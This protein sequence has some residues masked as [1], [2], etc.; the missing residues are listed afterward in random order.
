M[1]IE[2][3]IWVIGLHGSKLTNRLEGAIQSRSNGEPK[4]TYSQARN[5]FKK[6]AE[7]KLLDAELLLKNG[8]ASNAYYLAGYAVEI[9]FKACIARQMVAETIPDKKLIIDT[10]SHEFN[11]LVGVAGLRSELKLQQDADHLFHANWGVA[12]QWAPSSR[13]DIVDASTAQFLV[14]AVAHPKHGVLQWIKKFW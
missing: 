10:Y 11:V 6:I 4:M 3:V 12:N 2:P 7:A 1:L 14:N 9:G 8:R 13:Y 5:T